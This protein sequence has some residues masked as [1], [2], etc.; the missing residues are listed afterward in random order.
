M[1]VVR[2][3]RNFTSAPMAGMIANAASQ[4]WAVRAATVNSTPTPRRQVIYQPA[5]NHCDGDPLQMVVSSERGA[6]PGP[7]AVE[8]GSLMAT[9]RRR[10]SLR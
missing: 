4:G 9:G 3:V 1:R 5:F 6:S 8:A 2:T 7:G 10:N